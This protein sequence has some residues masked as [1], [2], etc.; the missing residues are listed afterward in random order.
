MMHT[1][2]NINNV[3]ISG[4]LIAEY[5][6]SIWYTPNITY[7]KSNER[8]VVQLKCGQSVQQLVVKP[9][10][11]PHGRHGVISTFW[12]TS[13]RLDLLP[14]DQGSHRL[15]TR[16][17]AVSQGNILASCYDEKC[18]MSAE[19]L[20]SAVARVNRGFGRDVLTS[21]GLRKNSH[22]NKTSL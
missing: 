16:P 21:R 6:I 14:C 11:C 12:R 7:Q 13:H 1:V 4:G 22:L 8:W 20:I 15:L 17:P 5:K 10:H 9:S 18:M 3:V 2:I 19:E